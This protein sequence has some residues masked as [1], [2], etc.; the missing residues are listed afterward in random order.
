MKKQPIA[1]NETQSD[2][3]LR[4][5]MLLNEQ[6]TKQLEIA[7]QGNWLEKVKQLEDEKNALLDYI[8]DN[9]EKSQE[10]TQRAGDRK[11]SNEKLQQ[12]EYEKS[13]LY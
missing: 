8:E 5:E 2:A 11:D 3:A 12:L 7:N 1:S 13:K 10:N 9:I 6:L 4:K